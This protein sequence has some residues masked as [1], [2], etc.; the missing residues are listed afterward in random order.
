MYKSFRF[1]SVRA[2]LTANVRAF[3]LQCT[4]RAEQGGAREEEEAGRKSRRSI[5]KHEKRPDD[6]EGRCRGR[7]GKARNSREQRAR[8]EK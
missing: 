1:C 4:R 5:L 2:V 7:S 6:S 8:A 3:K